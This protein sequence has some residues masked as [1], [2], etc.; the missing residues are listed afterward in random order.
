MNQRLNV[1]LILKLVVRNVV[2]VSP[3]SLEILSGL[4]RV[5]P[6]HFRFGDDFTVSITFSADSNVAT[7]KGVDKPLTLTEAK[8]VR[9]ILKQYGLKMSYHTKREVTKFINDS[10]KE[11]TTN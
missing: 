5:G 10:Q 2:E 1:V 9:N 3:A 4:I 7:V 11:E 6:D 8:Q